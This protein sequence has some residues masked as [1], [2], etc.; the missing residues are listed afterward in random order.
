M[1]AVSV[2]RGKCTFARARASKRRSCA[3]A[4]M[5]FNARGSAFNLGARWPLAVGKPLARGS[6]G[7][8]TWR[9]RVATHP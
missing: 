1:H 7:P 9:Y 3:V 2:R 4:R 6:G 8:L 5:R